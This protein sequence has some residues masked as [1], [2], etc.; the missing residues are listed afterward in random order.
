MIKT[1]GKNV[2]FVISLGL[3]REI[4]Q[5]VDISGPKISLLRSRY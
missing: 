5:F 2:F 3:Q 1:K 4:T